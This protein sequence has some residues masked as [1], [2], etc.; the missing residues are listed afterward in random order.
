MLWQLDCPSTSILAFPA[1]SRAGL[2]LM[3][4]PLEWG[5]EPQ[6]KK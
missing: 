5:G 3:V 6:R 1:M 4:P 2:M